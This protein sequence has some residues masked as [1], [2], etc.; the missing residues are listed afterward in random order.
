M[1]NEFTITRAAASLP[2]SSTQALFSVSGGLVLVTKIVGVV[3]T[4]TSGAN[5]ATVKIGTTQGD[6][7]LL[8]G[9]PL[10]DCAVDDVL[11]KDSAS[12]STWHGAAVTPVP[13][14]PIVVND[15]A[16]ISLECDASTAGQV[17][18]LLTYEPLEPGAKIVA[19]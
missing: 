11:G 16:E 9:L 10:G 12:S 19:A 2:Q 4:A 13:L 5:S 6:F 18:W 8:S 7:P 14:R 17:R 15:G 1:S 3:T